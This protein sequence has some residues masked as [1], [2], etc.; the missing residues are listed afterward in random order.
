VRGE[1]A[2]ILSTPHLVS[3]APS[4]TLLAIRKAFLFG[5][6]QRSLLY[7]DALAFVPSA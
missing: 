2:V 5:A 4:R 3:F 7:Q 6:L 1:I